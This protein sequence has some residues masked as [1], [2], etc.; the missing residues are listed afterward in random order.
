MKADVGDNSENK[1]FP[2]HLNGNT[3]DS[4]VQFFRL[5]T[6]YI[7][8]AQVLFFQHERPTEW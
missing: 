8:F 7:Q 4:L 2:A 6:N 5:P 3:I 1:V